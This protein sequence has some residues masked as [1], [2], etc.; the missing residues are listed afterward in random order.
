[1]MFK[2]SPKHPDMSMYESLLNIMWKL[3]VHLLS[4]IIKMH[5][6]PGA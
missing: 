2:Y 1:M 6:K 3:A 4:G 5:K